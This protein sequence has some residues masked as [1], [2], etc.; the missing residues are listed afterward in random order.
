MSTIG[1]MAGLMAIPS[2]WSASAPAKFKT[3]TDWCTPLVTR[4]PKVSL[5]DCKNSKLTPTGAN[6]LN[7]FP[8]LY[9][10]LHSDSRH[11]QA[12][13][14]LL[15]GGIHGDEQTAS[16]IVFKWME[17]MQK[18]PLEFNWRV[19][20]VVNP[21]GLL[22]AQPKRVNARGIDLN[23]NF[24]TPNWQKEAPAYWARVT[25]SD[26][27]RYPGKAPISE[28]ESRWVYDTIEKYKPDVI[29]SV[30]APFGVLD[31]DG[32]A[33][34]P[35]RFGRLIYNRVGVYPG[36][37]GNYSGL[38][39]DIPVVT[40]ELPNATQMPPDVEVQRIWQDMQNWIRQN[41]AA[42]LKTSSN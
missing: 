36:S 7:G 22:A 10:D 8:V 3:V 34:P 31:F 27:R 37:L 13:R 26:P 19:A 23:R 1:A 38:H 18:A 33:T 42:P 20:P 35:N 40:I 15:L 14:V 6:S 16:S 12:I 4:L 9:R 2:A 32:P 39:K 25:R 17:S 24:P 11:P 21:D 28:P 5:N 41:V 29:I 30:H